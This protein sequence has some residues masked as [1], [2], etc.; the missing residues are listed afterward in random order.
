MSRE[1]ARHPV[2]A[3]DTSTCYSY[4]FSDRYKFDEKYTKPEKDSETVSEYLKPHINEGHIYIPNHVQEE[5]NKGIRSRIGR[6]LDKMK[7]YGRRRNKALL[8]IVEYYENKFEELCEQAKHF[9]ITGI[10]EAICDVEDLYCKKIPKY[11]WNSIINW[12]KDKGD[13]IY[14]PG[15]KRNGDRGILALVTAL[16]RKDDVWSPILFFT[17]DQDSISYKTPI[18]EILNVVVIYKHNNAIDRRKN[19]YGDPPDTLFNNIENKC[20]DQDIDKEITK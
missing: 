3:I 6:Q 14:P 10:D 5:F 12:E 16:G 7:I 15:K 1:S 8:E 13:T 9:E 19:K 20:D 2:V 4:L 17:L 11:Y 18:F